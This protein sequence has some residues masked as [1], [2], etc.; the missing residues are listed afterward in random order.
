MKK[1]WVEVLVGVKD[2]LCEWMNAFGRMADRLFEAKLDI[3]I[4]LDRLDP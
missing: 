1:L 4:Y 3:Q 2:A